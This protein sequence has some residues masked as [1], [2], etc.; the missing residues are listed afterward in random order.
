MKRFTTLVTIK[1]FLLGLA[2][3]S[4]VLLGG[5]EVRSRFVLISQ[6]ETD[7]TD[8]VLGVEI[9]RPHITPAKVGNEVFESEAISSIALDF[10]TLEVLYEHNPNIQVPMASTTKIMAAYVALEEFD[11]EH[12]ITVQ[13]EDIDVIGSILGLEEGEKIYMSELV[14]GMLVRSGNDAAHT[15][16]NE[17]ERNGKSLTSLMNMY[18]DILG[19]EN[20]NFVNASGLDEDNHFSSAKDLAIIAKFAMSHDSI[21]EAVNKPSVTIFKCRR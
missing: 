18:V 17:F 5:E 6:G 20:T 19:L 16:E 11:A 9:Q 3:L 15:L 13:K 8:G 14:K 7:E 10:N 12:I 1:F 2:F 4:L 21:R